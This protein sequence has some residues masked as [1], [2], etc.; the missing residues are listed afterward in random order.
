MAA[1]FEIYA[2]AKQT[3]CGLRRVINTEAEFQ[4]VRDHKE[5]ID[6]ERLRFVGRHL[7]QKTRKI[8]LRLVDHMNY[9]NNR[10]GIRPKF[11]YFLT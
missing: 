2:N 4:M 6:F 7:K 8:I 9:I 5:K 10:L 1:K 3:A 11:I